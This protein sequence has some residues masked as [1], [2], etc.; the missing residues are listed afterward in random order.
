MRRDETAKRSAKALR[1]SSRALRA[2]PR[3]LRE[4]LVTSGA[5]SPRYPGRP[6]RLE[7]RPVWVVP[8]TLFAV[9]MF[10]L[11][12]NEYAFRHGTGAGLGVLFAGIPSVA[13]VV[14][15]FRPLP[16]WW[17]STVVMFLAVP[18]AE[19]AGP[20]GRMPSPTGAGI[21][22]QAGVLFLLALRVRPRT[23]AEA[24]AIGVAAG[25]VGGAIDPVRHSDRAGLGAAVLVVAV[26]TGAVLRGLGLART[27][28]AAQEEQTAEERSRRTLL[29]E[30]NRIAR[31]LHDIVAHHMSAVSIQAQVA[32]HLVENPSDEL[33]EN[34]AGIRENALEALT[35]LR[36]VLGVLRSEDALS[37]AARHAP[38]PT[39][40][41][42]DELIGTARDAGLEVTAE[43][44]GQP[45]PLPPG[46]ELSAFRIVQEALGNAM[47]H[48]PGAQV[49]VEVGRRAAG[50]TVPVTNTAPERA[51][52]HPTGA[53][54]GLLGM[55]ERTAMLGGRL[56][57][58]A[59]A[60]GGYE[61]AATLPARPLPRTPGED[62][63]RPARRDRTPGRL[64]HGRTAPPTAGLAP[65]VLPTDIRMPWPGA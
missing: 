35:E 37:P 59:T 1:A 27:Q 10:V 49:A 17:A 64:R 56:A 25:L 54:H 26:V 29:E 5:D 24:L 15:L 43:T 38:Q 13:V 51:A 47:R 60:D 19:A 55:R 52:P 4:D 65:G 16:A 61:V 21:A 40:D 9:A 12:V 22:L 53:G 50:V 45:H 57:A 3:T 8:P 34:L 2:L 32:P 7:W 31:E 62:P 11:D 48:A 33:K 36:R 6:R 20:A 18:V 58:G 46:V 23:A 39:L 44:T 30:R 14:A 28:L 63:V 42:L 41:R